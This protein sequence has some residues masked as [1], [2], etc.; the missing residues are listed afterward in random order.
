[1]IKR[2]NR[3]TF[4]DDDLEQVEFVLDPDAEPGDVVPAL[5][6]LL[7]GLARRRREQL[8]AASATGAAG[9]GQLAEA[10]AR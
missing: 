10:E 7:I 1:M 2:A 9:E 6:K 8:A 5:A 4:A 3:R